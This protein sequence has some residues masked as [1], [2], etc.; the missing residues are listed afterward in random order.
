[1]VRAGELHG[2]ALGRLTVST[3]RSHPPQHQAAN[4]CTP[5]LAGSGAAAAGV[6]PSAQR[7]QAE[8]P[9]PASLS[10]PRLL[11]AMRLRH[12]LLDS[13][14]LLDVEAMGQAV[15]GSSDAESV[16][17]R[18]RLAVLGSLQP[19]LRDL[20]MT[21]G[22]SNG[23]G[24][25]CSCGSSAGSPVA[26]AGEQQ[27]EHELVAAVIAYWRDLLHS[28]PT[29]LRDDEQLLAAAAG[30]QQEWGTGGSLGSGSCNSGDSS[31]G[32]SDSSSPGSTEGSGK[33]GPRRRAAVEARLERKRLLQTGIEVLQRYLGLA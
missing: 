28:M 30:P 18:R 13:H 19:L 32:G 11:A 15:L 2:W 3:Q 22:S 14:G 10:A 25:S 33:L 29:S 16:Q 20:P 5:P 4:G 17:Q 1:M 27:G 7:N 6:Q 26:A 31:S 9:R 8:P 24:S 21:G 12:S 23:G